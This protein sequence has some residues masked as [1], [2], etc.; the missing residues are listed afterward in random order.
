MKFKSFDERVYQVRG[1]D[2]KHTSF[3]NYRRK[4]VSTLRLRSVNLSDNIDEFE[5][6][7]KEETTPEL[8][9]MKIGANVRE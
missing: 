2:R 4:T 6:E 1:Q 3:K 8:Y 7:R 9:N 5:E